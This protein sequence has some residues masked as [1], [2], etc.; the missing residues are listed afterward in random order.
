MVMAAKR[1]YAASS[2]AQQPIS[3]SEGS[4]QWASLFLLFIPTIV[5][6]LQLST[7]STAEHNSPVKALLTFSFSVSRPMVVFP[8]SARDESPSKQLAICL[9]AFS[10]NP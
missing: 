2:A 1:R 6:G 7:N 9:I 3:S 5:L 10:R 8:I 4:F